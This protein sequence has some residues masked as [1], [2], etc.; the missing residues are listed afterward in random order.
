MKIL[1]ATDGSDTALAALDFVLRFPLP[2]GSEIRLLT[3]IDRNGLP[4]LA[5]S[6]LTEEQRHALAETEQTVRHAAER[7]LAE[8]G[9]RLRHA[10]W[11]GSTEVRAG[12]PADEIRRAAQESGADLVVL[13]SHGHRGF[14]RFILGSVSGGVLQYAP[15]SVLVIPPAAQAK[16]EE[17]APLRILIAFDG[18]APA[19]KAVD[20]C[21]GLP[22]RDRAEVTL[23]TVMPLVTLYRQD[24]RQRLSWHWNK[25]KKAAGAA[26]E[27]AADRIRWATPRVTTLLREDADEAGTI[28]AVAGDRQTDLIVVGH[29]GRSAI[30]RVL[31]GS[32]TGRIAAHAPCAVLA[33]RG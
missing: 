16:R 26:L 30:A 19:E 1:F 6:G 14:R 5:P 20:L 25:Q 22:L 8:E 23:L 27:R 29:K 21:A 3:V 24:I 9:A 13:G 33:V 10:G 17:Q 18:S 31:L 4:Q 11:A 32:V 12:H 7:L 28:L 2:E 15:C